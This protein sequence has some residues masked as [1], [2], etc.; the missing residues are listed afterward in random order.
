VAARTCRGFRP[1]GRARKRLNV[2]RRRAGMPLGRMR[3]RTTSLR[4]PRKRR[5]IALNGRTTGGLQDRPRKCCIPPT[6]LERPPPSGA[7]GALSRSQPR[8][9]LCRRSHLARCRRPAS[10]GALQTKAPR[11][12][13]ADDDARG[14]PRPRACHRGRPRSGALT[15]PGR[16]VD[17]AGASPGQSGSASVAPP[18]SLS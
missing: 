14:R 1:G 10:R 9:G 11:L 12:V 15:S 7:G 2:T 5:R 18:D 13:P 8:P 17:V 6:W 16:R 3:T 4:R